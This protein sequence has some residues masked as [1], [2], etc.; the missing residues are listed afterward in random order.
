MLQLTA[1]TV[2]AIYSYGSGVKSASKDK[3][4]IIDQLLGLQRVL[5]EVEVLARDDEDKTTSQLSTL[6]QLLN[7]PEGLPR[8]KEIL[9][10]FKAKLE[11]RHGR[12]HIR[13]VLSWPLRENDV[14]KTVEYL[15]DFPQL[16]QST[17][18]LDQMYVSLFSPPQL[19]IV[20]NFLIDG[21]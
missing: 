12:S 21:W 14:R 11:P 9:T 4:S 17:M 20:L 6:A 18:N 2:T 3:K 15:E 16:L 7:S 1:A 19:N 13:E 8:C 10:N 5:G